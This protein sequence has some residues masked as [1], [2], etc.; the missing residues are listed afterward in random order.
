MAMYEYTITYRSTATHEN[1]DAMS[2]LPLPESPQVTP[3]PPEMILLMEELNTTPITAERIRVWTNSDQLCSCVG[4]FVQSGWPDSVQDGKL[5][6]FA[7]RKDELSLKDGC[8]LWGNQVVI[9]C[10]IDKRDS[11]TES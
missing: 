2:R 8:I 7:T 5:K 4:Q 10:P 1:A 6:P 11:E 3:L 9:K